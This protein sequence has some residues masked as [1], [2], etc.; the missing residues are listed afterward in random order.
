M[1]DDACDNVR[2]GMYGSVNS[3]ACVTWGIETDDIIMKDDAGTSLSI[4]S[5]LDL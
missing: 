3:I 1:R 2:T 4:G 5:L